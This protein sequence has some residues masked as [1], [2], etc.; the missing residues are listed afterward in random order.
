MEKRILIIKLGSM[1]DVLRTTPILRAI[2][3]RF[4]FCHITWLTYAD[5]ADLLDGNKFIDRIYGFTL[6]NILKLQIEEFDFLINLDKEEEALAL[7]MLIKAKEKMGYGMSKDGKII[8]L[9][10]E[11][12]YSIKLGFDDNLKFRINKKTYQQMIFDIVRLPYDLRYEYVLALP[13]EAVAAVGNFLSLHNIN[14]EDTVIG[15]NTGAGRKFANKNLSAETIAKLIDKIAKEL[16]VK[17]ILLGGALEVSINREIKSLV[18][19]P[20]IDSGCMEIKDF[21]AL[22]NSCNLIISGDTLTLHIAIALR[23][24]VV[25]LFGPTCAQEIELYGRGLK[26]ISPKE[27]TPCYRKACKRKPNCMDKIPVE[28]L[29]NSIA[30]VGFNI[31]PEIL[32]NK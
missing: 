32:L 29:F 2:R 5:S 10:P 11:S 20:I 4:L 13:K 31:Q 6:Q 27:C 22:I 17:V 15:I 16:A 21:A 24:P 7:A 12:E 14:G 19:T 18:S 23:K 25:A 1:G 30:K 8:P 9:N 28:E 26:I 3:K